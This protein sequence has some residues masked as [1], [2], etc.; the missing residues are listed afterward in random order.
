M[1]NNVLPY[2]ERIMCP[3][4][5]RLPR[6]DPPVRGEDDGDLRKGGGSRSQIPS[7]LTGIIKTTKASSLEPF[8]TTGQD[9]PPITVLTCVLAFLSPSD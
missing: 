3:C 8:T 2:C 4:T 7:H 6:T 5:G 9:R 1:A